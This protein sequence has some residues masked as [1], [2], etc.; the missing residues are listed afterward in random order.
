M[1]FDEIQRFYDL[2]ADREDELGV[3]G[4]KLLGEALKTLAQKGD[5][6]EDGEI[7]D[8]FGRLR[9]AIGEHRADDVD[10]LSQ[11]RMTLDLLAQVARAPVNP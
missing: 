1:T 6:D 4:R 8:L 5:V 2:V 3:L 7:V 11:M 9:R 10:R